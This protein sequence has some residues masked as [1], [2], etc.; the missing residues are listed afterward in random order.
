MS[1]NRK[2]DMIGRKVLVKLLDR[3]KFVDTLKSETRMFV[4]LAERG[5]LRRDT[6]KKIAPYIDQ[7]F[8]WATTQY[9]EQ[10][11]LKQSR[12]FPN[13]CPI[14]VWQYAQ[15]GHYKTCTKPLCNNGHCQEHGKVR[16]DIREA[17]ENGKRR[18]RPMLRYTPPR[19]RAG[20]NRTIPKA[21]R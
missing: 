11:D 4:V 9:A 1:A 19:R 15:D 3:T 16:Y 14:R 10:F 17:Q 21:Y 18:Q 12:E 20:I 6:I 2:K 7:G 13:L 5:R 8:V